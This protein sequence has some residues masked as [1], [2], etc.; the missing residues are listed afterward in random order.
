MQVRSEQIRRLRREKDLSQE[1]MAEILGLSQSQYSRIESGESRIN[2][3]KANRIAEILNVN[4][5]KILSYYNQ[6]QFNAFWNHDSIN[7]IKKL[8]NDQERQ[9]YI[10]QIKELKADKEFLKSE[11][12]FLKQMLDNFMKK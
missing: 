6:K 9:L 4:P 7:L 8:D 12:Q 5:Q 1:Y 11:N 10:D 2:L 3:D